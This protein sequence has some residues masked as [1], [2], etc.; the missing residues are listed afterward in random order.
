MKKLVISL[1]LS[2]LSFVSAANAITPERFKELVTRVESCEAILEEF[3]RRPETAIPAD[4]LAKARAIVIVNQV[5]AGVVIGLQEGYGVLLVKRSD[6]TWSLPALIRAGETSFGLQLGVTTVETI[7]VITDDETPRKIF[8]S[9]INLGVD[10][11]AVAGPKFAD[12]Q[13]T[14]KPIIDAPVLVYTKKAGLYAGATVKAGYISRNDVDTCALYSTTN[15]LPELLYS[16]W[17]SEIP[18]VKPLR[19]LVKRIAP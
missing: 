7:F 11:K 13:K 1:F 12:S 17:V 4:V 15:A 5:K 16:D 6:G 10:A 3:Q 19:D 2:V 8:H 9:R 18:E 14:N